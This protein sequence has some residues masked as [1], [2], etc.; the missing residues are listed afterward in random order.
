MPRFN[1]ENMIAELDRFGKTYKYPVFVTVSVQNGI[2]GAKP[3]IRHGYAAISDD[4]FL[5]IVD[6]ESADS[7]EAVCHRLPVTG[8]SSVR[9]RKADKMNIFTVRLKGITSESKKYRIKVTVAGTEV[10][11]G[12]PDQV[13]N[14]AKFVERFRKWSGEI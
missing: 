14:C 2:L 4:H 12:L 1:K 3:I 13:E 9:V 7:E 11:N 6:Y 5:L 10:E 8:M